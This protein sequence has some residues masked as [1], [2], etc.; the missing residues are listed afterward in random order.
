MSSALKTPPLLTEDITYAE[1]KKDLGIWKLLTELTKKKQGPAL[2][3]TL[4]PKA[5]ECLRS[6]TENEIGGDTGLDLILNKLDGFYVDDENLQSFSA[7]KLFYDFRRPSGMTM[8]DF[9]I[10]YES[11]YHKL[12]TFDMKLP[13]GVQSFFLLT[14]ANVSEDNERLA[15]VS[16]KDLK[17]SSMKDTLIKIFAEPAATIEE[18]RA[19][20]VK[21]EPVLKVSH[22]G[23][24]RGRGASYRGG[25]RGGFGQAQSDRKNPTD[26]DGKTMTCHKC[27]SEYHFARYCDKSGKSGK[28]K[29]PENSEKKPV[30]ITLLGNSNSEERM[31]RLLS[32]S[33]GMAVLDTGCSRTVVGKVW[34]NEYEETLTEDEKA[35][36]ETSSSDTSFV[37]GDGEEVKATKK[38]LLP[39]TL[40][41]K[42][43]KIEAEVVKND[44]PLLFSRPSMKRGGVI[45]NT[46]ENKAEIL[47]E[48]VDLVQTSSGHICL[49]LTNKLLIGDWEKYI[50]L[51]TS[52]IE[53]CNKDQKKR[54]AMK[55]HRQFSH[56]NKEPL[57]KLV[58][59]SKDFN[60]DKEF[61]EY[62]GDCCDN[63]PI[64]K[65][66]KRPKL[67]PVVTLPL[68]S[69][70]NEVVCMDLKEHIH[71]Q[72]WVLHLIDSATKYSAGRIVYTK[73]QDAIIQA[74]FSSWIA[75]FG[76]PRM[77][78]SDNG[79]EFNN[80]GY[81]EMNEQL[82]VHT[83]T[84]AAESPFS[85]GTVERH[86][87]IVGESMMKTMESE[88]CTADLALS[89][90][91]AAKNSM[92][93]YGG[94]S[95]NMMVFGRNANFPNILVDK[96]PALEPRTVNDIVRKNIN[97]I[98]TARQ[99]YV[100]A[101]SSEKIRKALRSKVRNYA[102]VNYE[103]GEQ[104]YYRRRKYKGWKGPARVLGQDGK[105]VMLRHGGELVRVHPCHLM[106]DWEWELA[107]NNKKCET[108]EQKNSSTSSKVI[109]E[110]VESDE[111]ESMDEVEAEEEAEEVDEEEESEEEYE[112]EQESAEYDSED[113]GDNEETEDSN[114]QMNTGNIQPKRNRYVKYKLKDHNEWKFAKILSSQPKKTGKY[115][116]FINIKNDDSDPECLDWNSVSEWCEMPS[117]E[118]LVLLSTENEFSQEVVDAKDREL[119]S[120][121]ANRV[122]ETVP[123]CGQNTVS[124]KWVLSE[125]FKDGE[126]IM[127]ARLVAR[128]Y[129]ENTINL[130]KDS[131]TCSKEGQRLVYYTA[132]TKSWKIRSL[133]FTSAFLQGEEIER[134]VFLRPPRDV[135]DKQEIWKLRKCIYGLT[136]APRRWYTNIKKTL[137]K[138]G[139]SQSAYDSALYIW[140]GKDGDIRGIIAA[141]VDDFAYAGCES[142]Q[143]DV[144]GKLKTE[145]KIGQECESNFK[146][147]GLSVTQSKGQVKVNQDDYISSIEHINIGKGRMQDSELT[148]EEKSEL[149]CLAGK[150]IWAAS[151][152]RP[153]VAYE[154]CVMSNTGQHPTVKMMKD[155]NKAVTK[156]KSK[157]VSIN[158]KNLGQPSKVKVK[159]YTD[160]THASLQDG[161]SQGGFIAFLEGNKGE[162]VPMVWKSKKLHRVTKS[163]LASETLAL[164]EGADAGFLLA[165]LWTDIATSSTLCNR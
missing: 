95:S 142:F 113:V 107:S 143:S 66:Y 15:R 119:E 141:H 59:S 120:L 145:F 46:K 56:A 135:C 102:D 51:N 39:V 7:F 131:P 111:D 117:P 33:L 146:Y 122:F 31:S 65:K 94:I 89:W 4:P 75:Y 90:A 162:L 121:K 157:S 27:G 139:G 129:E 67:R 54:K 70:F 23:S 150:M 17:Y 2:Y 124:S 112:G 49:P 10:K 144:I 153:D 47:G 83:A 69:D 58:K 53:H 123:Y 43:V 25:F 80:E 160:A 62:I 13:E 103:T 19:P 161:S 14:A 26:S 40:G 158:Y 110:N 9:V 20:A 163:P 99:K 16:C 114:Q 87:S 147:V 82:N 164:G 11:L 152:T 35:L 134:E 32:E 78:L 77:F 73:R 132:A 5:R 136:D 85:N 72:S 60:N 106:K 84:T 38:V 96:P 30:Y 138:L 98:H 63:C 116:H 64:C 97:A 45:I 125:K 8:R 24:Y 68:A 151:Q 34:L 29:S 105:I 148:C 1:W 74:V 57:L 42:L 37:F 79:G 88:K 28:E 126:K 133:D 109:E 156:L 81:R 55:L 93:S 154:T 18:E 104:V 108:S 92:Q 86:N 140:H 137:L 149:K 52:S 130:R 115:Y 118:F 6:L 12:T 128:G 159:V 165:G 61:L 91:L 22:R 127:K 48:V 101:E 41:S 76:T 36:I 44:I 3:L 100:Q 155:A 50:V 21:L 71:N